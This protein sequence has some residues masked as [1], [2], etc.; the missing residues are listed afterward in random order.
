MKKATK[1]SSDFVTKKISVLKITYEK[2]TR[3]I[4][5]EEEVYTSSFT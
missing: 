3:P 5:K 2:I 4:K 1:Y